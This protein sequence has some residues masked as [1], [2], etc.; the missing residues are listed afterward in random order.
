MNIVHCIG[1][2]NKIAGY[3]IRQ[4]ISKIDRNEYR[5]IGDLLILEDEKSTPVKC[6]KYYYYAPDGKNML[7]DKRTKDDTPRSCHNIRQE[8]S[9]ISDSFT[10]FDA[11]ECHR[12]HKLALE[13][14]DRKDLKRN[15]EAIKRQV[16]K[17]SLKRKK[18][19]LL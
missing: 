13:Y 12:C 10:D 6:I 14:F 9:K 5:K 2:H 4:L 11:Y 3:E 18:P 19:K 8:M 16:K 15:G 1:M 17:T 7:S